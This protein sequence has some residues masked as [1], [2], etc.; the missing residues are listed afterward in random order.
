MKTAASGFY[1]AIYPKQYIAYRAPKTS[2]ESGSFFLDGNLD[3]SFW[4]DVPWTDDF[5]DIATDIRPKFRTR[6][7]MRW[8]EDFLYVGAMMEETDVWGTLIE[9]NSV[10][11]HD[12]DFEVFVDTD[13][14]N[15]N[16]KEFEINALG[17]TWSLLLNKPYADCGAEDSKR[18]NPE[19]GYDMEP[20]LKSAVAVYPGN[21]INKPDITNTHWTT[22][23]A[24]PISKLMERNPNSQ[25]PTDGVFW[26]VN[27]SRVQWSVNVKGGQ[28]EK[29][30][31]CQ[32]CATPGAEA[33]DNWVWSRQG[34]VAMHL[35]E[36][37]GVVQFSS[38]SP[39]QVE[40][41]RYDEWSSRCAAMALYYSLKGY[42]EKEG[43]YTDNID[44]LRSFSK[45]PFLICDDSKMTIVI[46]DDG[47][48]ATAAIDSHTAIVNQERYLVV[49]SDN[50]F[51]SEV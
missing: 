21:A 4:T 10:I 6:V 3:K 34:E 44:A 42:H 49:S 32:S 50:S 11:F 24:L 27:F 30:P 14:T 25:K 48:E 13:G 23:I 16:Y 41:A 22:E 39:T 17:T 15:H 5:V 18:V 45:P 7:K 37:W 35:P 2:S 28:Y 38:K 1:D 51:I 20:P 26:R 9:H 8:D 46:T 19:G 12:N 36:R 40:M 31:C 47:F 29:A 33:E 43:R